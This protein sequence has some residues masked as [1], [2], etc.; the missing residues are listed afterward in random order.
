MQ[1]WS[2]D[3][4]CDMLH[5]SFKTDFDSVVPQMNEEGQKKKE[6]LN[7]RCMIAFG[8]QSKEDD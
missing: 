2:K 1:I 5:S 8:L 6:K 4:F 3:G 7:A